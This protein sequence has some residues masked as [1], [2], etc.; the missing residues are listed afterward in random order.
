LIIERV[1]IVPDP[2]S[3]FCH[4]V[5]DEENAVTSRRGSRSGLDR[6]ADDRIS[7]GFNCG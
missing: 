3:W 4:L 1:L 6:G 5:T 7:P 2:G